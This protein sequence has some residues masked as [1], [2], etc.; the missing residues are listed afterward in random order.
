MNGADVGTMR[1][2]GSRRPMLMWEA[3]TVES[4][5]PIEYELQYSTNAGMLG[6]ES[7]TTEREEYQFE[8]ELDAEVLPP[9]GK[10]Y[11]W[12]VRACSREN[13]SSF[14]PVWWFNVGRVK[15]DFNAD[16]YDDVAVS[17]TAITM[18]RYN[19]IYFYYGSFG[20][21]FDAMPN[22]MKSTSDST[23]HG[24]GTA[25]SCAGD[26]NGDGLADV[27]VGAPFS[28]DLRGE[29][30]VLFGHAGEIFSASSVDAI[31]GA[32]DGGQLGGS[33]AAAGDVNGDGFDDVIAG[34]WDGPRAH[35][36]MG[37]PSGR[38][39]PP[40]ELSMDTSASGVLTMVS[41]A[42]DVDGDGFSDVIVSFLPGSPSGPQAIRLYLGGSGAK[43]DATPDAELVVPMEDQNFGAS[44]A[45]AGDVNGDG[46]GDVIVGSSGVNRAYV[47]LGGP[48]GLASAPDLTLEG[49]E[50]TNFGLVVASAGDM[51]GDG[52]SDV[53]VGTSDYNSSPAAVYI[54]MG[55]AGATLDD[56]PDVAIHRPAQGDGFGL[57]LASPGDVNGDGYSDLMV[58]APS[59]DAVYVFFGASEAAAIATGGGSVSQ[60]LPDLA[61]GT[62]VSRR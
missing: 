57:A 36:C 47:Y 20:S 51:N 59:N 21:M 8:S 39:S 10:R 4:N 37:G 32:H 13:C 56:R 16:G 1:K 14:S 42:G 24:F 31:H 11:Y 46:F 9:V 2:I 48:E 7:I 53:A 28:D 22:G 5:L 52:F 27:L 62:A 50:R 29:A 41:S 12:R 38:L 49:Q 26:V 60:S 6:A 43:F 44:I 40:V 45:S 54:Y 35:L 34:E 19:T 33:V 15:C 30:Q 61:F 3:S 58:A 25:L 18:S 23:V 55:G 17:A